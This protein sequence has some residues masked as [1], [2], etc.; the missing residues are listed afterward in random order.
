MFE[1]L[2][3]ILSSMPFCG[4]FVHRASVLACFGAGASTACVVDIGASKTSI[5]QVV[6]GV[7]VPFT[8]RRCSYGGDTLTRL[9]LWM[10]Q[11]ADHHFSFSACDL[12]NPHDF[13]ELDHLKIRHCR[14]SDVSFSF[15]VV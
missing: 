12:D 4:L 10:L 13:I 6:D 5:S 2:M 1:L 14:F 11:N 15:I 9:F 8:Q 7:L 3:I